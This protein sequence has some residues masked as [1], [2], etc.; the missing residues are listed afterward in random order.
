MLLRLL[1]KEGHEVQV[2]MTG[3]AKAFI[4]PLTLSTLSRWPVVS[5]FYDTQSGEWVNHVE[6]ANWADLILIAPLSANTLSKM[7]NGACD[8]V[9]LATYL[10][11]TC[12]VWVAPAMDRDMYLHPATQHNLT[13]LESYGNV[14]IPPGTGELA[15]GLEGIGR[16]AEPEEI[17][18]AVKKK[19]LI[20]QDH[21]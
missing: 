10:S 9:L 16:M 20:Q 7:A 14:I 21:L 4:T 3:S 1:V 11:A 13:K 15:S 5:D 6:L 2:I 17:L 18:S 19:V 12:P 8:N